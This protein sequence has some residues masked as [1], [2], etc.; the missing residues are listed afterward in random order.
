MG[1]FDHA[2]TESTD[3]QLHHGPVVQDLRDKTSSARKLKSHKPTVLQR[4]SV[5]EPGQGGRRA[6]CCPVS[7]S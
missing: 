1:V 5:C 6:G 3:A 2:L 4:E 7:G